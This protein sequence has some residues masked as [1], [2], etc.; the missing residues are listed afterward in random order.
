VLFD[1]DGVLVDSLASVSTA[2]S[3][4]ARDLGLEPGRVSSLVHGRRSVDTVAMLV[5]EAQRA[6]QLAL[7]DR[8]EIEDAA[9]VRAIAGAWDLLSSLPGDRWAVVTSGRA[10]LARARLRA[11]GLPCPEALVTA[12]D[13]AQGKPDPEGY[14]KAAE[15]LG[16]EAKEA[17][18]V[19]DMP[20]GIRAA[21]AA[22]A[23]GVVGVGESAEGAGADLVVPDLRSLRWTGAGLEV[24][25][26]V[27]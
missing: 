22:G 24:L 23:G 17:V 3:R 11:A 7:I 5:P 8:Y 4:W 2:W 15:R 6:E 9:T 25:L 12:D 13:V 20:V 1:C 10:E 19:E 16:I 21:R 26:E 14:R 18:V 27:H